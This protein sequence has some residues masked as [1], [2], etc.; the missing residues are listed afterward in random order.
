MFICNFWGFSKQILEMFFPHL[1]SFF[2]TGCY[3]LNIVVLFLLLTSFTVCHAIRD[4]LSSTEF[5]I[6][7]IWPWMYSIY[8]FCNIFIRW[9]CV[10]L[11]FWALA[12]VWILL[13]HR[14]A[15]FTLSRFFLSAI[16]FL[17]TLC[18]ALS[19]VV[20]HSSVA[21]ASIWAW[22]KFSYSSLEVSVSDVSWRASNDSRTS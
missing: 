12:L 18:L 15:V 7:L 16:V 3:S 9:F 20:M 6:L 5:L 21:A 8:S 13:L 4:C 11:S 17:G 10:F 22:T 1:Y 14:N 19:L 2:L